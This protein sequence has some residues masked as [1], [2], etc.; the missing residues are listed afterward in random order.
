MSTNP[1]SSALPLQVLSLIS[2]HALS[3]AGF[4]TSSS[5]AQSTLTTSLHHYILLLSRLSVENANLATGRSRPSIEDVIEILEEEFGV[6]VDDLETWVE[7]G[8]WGRL[9]DGENAIMDGLEGL[10]R[11]YALSLWLSIPALDCAD[12]RKRN[13]SKMN[14]VSNLNILGLHCLPFLLNS[15]IL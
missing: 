7:D 13:Q 5:L 14:L 1:S 2:A 10:R 3:S 11:E 12:I 6:E 15:S 8:E 9:G 4:F